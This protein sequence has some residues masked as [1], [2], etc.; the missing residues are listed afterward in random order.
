MLNRPSILDEPLIRYGA[1][2]Y[3]ELHSRQSW[4]RLLDTLAAQSMNLVRI[5]DSAWGHVEPSPGRF[6]F[7]WLREALD[8]VA[9]RG[10]HAIVGTGTY[11]PPQWLLG[12]YPDALVVRADGQRLHPH[13]RKAACLNHGGYRAAAMRMVAALAAAVGDHPAVLGWQI[14]NEIDALTEPCYCAACEKRFTQWLRERFQTVQDLNQRLGLRHWGMM[15]DRFEQLPQSRVAMENLP[16]GPLAVRLATL[17]FRRDLIMQFLAEQA[18]ALRHA[19]ADQPVLHDW[20][21][22]RTQLIND[23]AATALLDIAGLNL[24]PAEAHDPAPWKQR[25]AAQD[26]ARGAQGVGRLLITETWTGTLGGEQVWSVQPGRQLLR[27]SILQCVAFGATGILYW[28]ARN[29][30]GGSWPHWGGLLDWSDRP[31]PELQWIAEIGATL[32]RW[33][34]TLASH[35]VQASAAVLSDYDQQSALEVYPHMPGRWEIADGAFDVCHRLGIG[36]DGIN[37]RQLAEER[38]LSRYQF[39]IL[40]AAPCTLAD[41]AINAIRRRVESGGTLLVG[42]IVDYQSVDGLFRTDGLGNSLRELTGVVTG[43]VRR[44]GTARQGVERDYQLH[45]TEGSRRTPIQAADGW[46]EVLHLCRAT[47]R[48][49]DVQILARYEPQMPAVG[50]QIAITRRTLGRGIVIRIGCW[51][52]DE[53]ICRL[54]HELGIGHG[55]LTSPLPPDVRAVPR[56]D[57][58]LWLLNYA[59]QPQRLRLKAPV[60]DRL[61]ART[62]DADLLLAGHELLW[63]EPP[64]T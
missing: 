36:V 50:G 33:G 40:A 12:E 39:I 37:A 53:A 27:L 26:I 17:R 6:E 10:M 56:T 48:E 49:S 5:N 7:D 31:A 61:T 54:L 52:S 19:G 38:R 60:R 3:P 64:G 46:C 55:L 32:A 57:G 2:V 58:S 45:W 35:P 9:A 29:W 18:A 13:S 43:A 1:S 15:I 22:R 16:R 51:P 23:P 34:P 21:P 11:I 63:I 25:L 41:D 47:A 30:A 59:P 42:P 28:P 8:D 20:M 44:M 62:M 4:L 24:Y 14:D